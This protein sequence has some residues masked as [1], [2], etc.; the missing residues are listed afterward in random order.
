MNQLI[1]WKDLYLFWGSH[2]RAISEHQHPLIQL[3]IAV[4]Q[5][6]LWKNQSGE[7]IEKK[8]LLTAP[9]KRHECDAQGKEVLI[10]SIDPESLLGH[11]IQNELMLRERQALFLE[12]SVSDIDYQ[13]LKSEIQQKKFQ[14]VYQY[15]LE[16][17][18]YQPGF[19]QLGQKDKRIQKVQD[20]IEQNI[21]RPLSTQ[22]LKEVVCLSESRLLHLF[23]EAV[24]LPIRNYIL[25]CRI[26]LALDHI[27]G[28][29]SLT[30]AAHYA[31]NP[32]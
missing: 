8:Y 32:I 9:H 30:E 19:G 11:F 26:R 6:F 24:G 12:Q 25:W 18:D 3:V 28:G 14:R 1:I 16:F 27:L 31:G 4:Q 13:L 7:W 5:P 20:Y 17:F 22:T 21:H 15:W 10:I 23:K 2:Q 29:H